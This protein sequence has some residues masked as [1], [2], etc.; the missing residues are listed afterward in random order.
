M[1]V[2]TAVEYLP[3]A[4]R[5]SAISSATVARHVRV[6]VFLLV[7]TLFVVPA[8]VRAT[9]SLRES[10]PS[11]IRLSRGFELP[12]TKCS[13]APPPDVTVPAV[14][15][16]EPELRRINRRALAFD[17]FLPDSFLD[18]SPEALR[19]PPNAQLA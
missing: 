5:M 13:I 8:L 15:V 2:R 4:K 18:S 9:K 10:T 16:V 11:P 7:A 17:E 12:P 3:H 6:G 14:S 1:A 19:G